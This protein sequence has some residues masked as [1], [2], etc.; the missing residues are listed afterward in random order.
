MVEETLHEPE[1]N[2]CFM[3]SSMSGTGPGA[4]FEFELNHSSFSS[5]AIHAADSLHFPH[6]LKISSVSVT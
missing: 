6:V 4:G 2:V 3:Q 5:V 1:L